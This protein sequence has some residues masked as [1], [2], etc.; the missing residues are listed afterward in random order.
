MG[1]EGQTEA[2]PSSSGVNPQQS[3][4]QQTGT[5]TAEDA[6]I[7]Q[8]LSAVIAES[9]EQQQESELAPSTGNGPKSDYLT[10]WKAAVQRC[11]LFNGL[12][13]AEEKF[14]LQASKYM[15]AKEGDVLFAMGDAPSMLYLVHSGS[16]MATICNTDGSTTN[17]RVYGPGD[18]FGAC[19]LLTQ[20]GGRSCTITTTDAGMVWAVPRRVVDV[21][22]KS[23]PPL[24]A[25]LL[26]FC[27]GVAL[28]NAL[29]RDR[30]AQ[31]CRGAVQVSLKA[32]EPV[33]VE[34]EPARDIYVLKAGSLKA[35]ATSFSLDVHPPE[36]F[37]EA[38]LFA[39]GEHR[40]RRATIRAAEGGASL[41]R[42]SVQAIE[43]LVGYALQGSSTRV[44][45]LKML[46]QVKLGERLLVEGLTRDGLNQFL[47]SMV[48]RT[49]GEKEM[50]AN[51]G[52]LDDA[53]YVIKSGEAL[54]KKSGGKEEVCMLRRG[55][56]FGEQALLGAASTIKAGK[57]RASVAVQGQELVVLS[58]TAEALAAIAEPLR[59]WMPE[60]GTRL[61]ELAAKNGV[62][63]DAAVAAC[64]GDKAQTVFPASKVPNARPGARVGK[65]DKEGGR[66]G[67]RSKPAGIE[68]SKASTSRRASAGGAGPGAAPVPV[69]GAGGGGTLRDKPLPTP[70]KG[71]GVAHRASVDAGSK[72]I[73]S[74]REKGTGTARSQR[75]AGTPNAVRSGS[76]APKDAVRSGS[77]PSA[78]SGKPMSLA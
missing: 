6:S 3:N 25:G 10:K 66:I 40:V 13:K 75:R 23:P 33:F 18:N 44:F 24:P 67:A 55:E 37:G 51:E 47:A 12:S 78:R 7:T 68:L 65:D 2:G 61:Q 74:A 21:K 42:W 45:N 1:P 59:E 54:V 46:A 36:S 71:R 63:V 39:D 14:V 29:T 19:E 26:D 38:A 35:E 27:N 70:T 60:L 20:M 62:G 73:K 53:M 76:I 69:D 49:Y 77:A 11:V 4:A 16:Y 43:T 50:V 52:E 22:L 9:S 32:G 41:V 5:E 8:K 34:D 72:G 57:R 17:L 30:L 28:F 64:L 56:C 58:L 31:L 15:E 48:E